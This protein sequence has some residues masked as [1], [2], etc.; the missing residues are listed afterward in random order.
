MGSPGSVSPPK[1]PDPPPLP[2]ERE[3]PK[4]VARGIARRRRGF[5]QTIL[6]GSLIPELGGKRRLGE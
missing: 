5:R 2:E 1:V 4:D 6:T 3:E